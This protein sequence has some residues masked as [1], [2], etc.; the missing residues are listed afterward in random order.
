MT[1]RGSSDGPLLQ[2]EDLRLYYAGEH[3]DVRAVD[4]VSFEIG[5]GETMAIVGE[6]GSGKTSL[7]LALLHL[8]PRN[9]AVHDGSVALAGESIMEL[10]EGDFRE[11][12]RWRQ[13]SMVFQGA[14]ESM[15]PVFKVGHQVAE[16]L[17]A[18]KERP[19]HEAYEVAREYM[20][21]V[22]LP[23]E[24]FDRYPHELS[25][26]MKQRAVIATALILEPS[27]VILD[28]PT[29]ALDVGVQAQIMNLFKRLKRDLGLAS[30]FITHDI[31]LASDL[32][33]SIAVMYAGEIVEIGP[34]ED[35]LRRPTH[36]Y[37]QRLLA[38]IPRLRSDDPLQ[39]IPGVPPD[40][41]DPPIGCRFH[42]RC[43]F[44]FDRCQEQAP[45]TF[46]AAEGEATAR[47]WLL[48]GSSRAP[49]V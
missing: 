41:T 5:A 19:K 35:V 46:Q 38:A 26:G 16:P 30:L 32:A 29:S 18:R 27:L 37:T 12:V 34:S 28:E 17:T 23:P 21:L 9:V 6:S 25:G 2:V 20:G 45:P 24:T 15:N 1:A 7:A 22:K 42:P 8:L 33:D 10:T 49:R 48:D 36:P 44:A 11:R 47:C 14:T 13:I 4:G 3:G 39:F 40:L 43:P 31:A